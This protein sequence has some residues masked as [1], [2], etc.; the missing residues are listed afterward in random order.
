MKVNTPLPSVQKEQVRPRA[1]RKGRDI[2]ANVTMSL[3][4]QV[5]ILLLELYAF[6]Q[7]VRMLLIRFSIGK[8]LNETTVP[9]IVINCFWASLDFIG[10]V[11]H[12]LHGHTVI[13]WL[14]MIQS[15]NFKPIYRDEKATQRFWM[16]F[17][18][19]IGSLRHVCP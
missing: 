8:P 6:R 14:F 16:S 9:H 12:I 13:D 11:V 4:H 10:I 18:G 2:H 1:R 19:G 5:L 3:V 17:T 7:P 15:G